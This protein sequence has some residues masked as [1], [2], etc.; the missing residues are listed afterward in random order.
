M[1]LQFSLFIVSGQ[2]Y[3]SGGFYKGYIV[4]KT[5]T[6]RCYVKNGNHFEKAKVVKYKFS[7]EGEVKE[8]D[9]EDVVAL[10]DNTSIYRKMTFKKRNYLMIEQ[11]KGP[12]SLYEQ[13]VT[14]RTSNGPQDYS[15]YYLE[16]SGQLVKVGLTTYKDDIKSV[17]TDDPETTA[18]IDKMKFGEVTAYI[19]AFVNN[20]N[21]KLKK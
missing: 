15:T 4:S 1:A 20:Y 2:S 6:I 13:V 18:K 3:L 21:A 12:V 19:Q 9:I 7:K 10:Y 5:D 8:V 16:K 14:Y 17:L 11:V